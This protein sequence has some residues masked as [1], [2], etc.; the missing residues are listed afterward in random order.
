MPEKQLHVLMKKYAGAEF[1]WV[2][3]EPKNMGAWL[4]V[5]RYEW[6]VKWQL[7]SRRSSS[8]PATGYASVHQ[9]EQADIINRA[10]TF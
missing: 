2:Q 8:T 4:H 9:A 5:L 10:F 6:P 7:I 3:E 1:A